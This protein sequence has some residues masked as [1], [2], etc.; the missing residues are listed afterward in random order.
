MSAA[1]HVNGFVA[2]LRD[3]DTKLT[4]LNILLMHIMT[5]LD[6]SKAVRELGWQPRPTPEAIV[7]AAHFFRDARRT[8][9]VAGQRR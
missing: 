5:P 2:R 6:H 4:A 1:G 8:A 7:A 3:K 9:T